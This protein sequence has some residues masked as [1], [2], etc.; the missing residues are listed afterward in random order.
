M[1]TL[2][3]K[4]LFF[5]L[6][7]GSLYLAWRSF[8]Q[9]ARVIQRGD[10]RLYMDELPRRIWR[11]LEVTVTQRTVFRARPW[12]SLMHGFVVWGFLFYFLANTGDVLEGYF[13][14][15]FL[16]TGIIG[17]VYRLAGDVLSVLIII[18]M[19]YFM[20]RRFVVRDPAL[21]YHE[22]VKLHPRIPGDIQR[23]SLIVGAF[24]LVHVGTRFLGETFWVALHGDDT[25]QPFASAV[26]GLWGGL[27]HDALEVG[28]HVLWWLA[29]GTIL[30]FIPYFPYSK[31]AHLF[32]GPLNY[33]SRPDRRSLGALDPLDFEDEAREQFGAAK[34]EHLSKTQIFDAFACIMCNRC[35]DACPAYV[36]G[37]ELSP[38]TLEINKR[39]EIKAHM[40]ALAAG[41]ESPSPLLDFAITPSA[42]WACTGCG[43]CIEIC[44][45]GNEPMFDIM[46]I[47]RDLVLTQGDFPSELQGAFRGMENAGN[48]WQVGESRMKWAEGLDVPTVEDTDN[49]EVLYWVGC[50]GSFEPRAQKIARALVRVLNAAGVKFA[51]L[52]DAESCTGDTARRAGNEY[53][54]YEMAK[55]NIETLNEVHPPR[56]L[57]TCPHCLHT[58]GKEYPQFGGNYDV[59]HHTTF[60]NELIQ[61]GRLKLVGEGRTNVTFHDPCYLGRHNGEYDAPRYALGA[62]GA[63]VTEMERTRNSSFCCGAGGAQFWK[64]EEHGT[65]R[66]NLTRYAEAKATGAETLATGC[67]F[68][69]RMFADARQDESMNG[70]P[71]VKDVVEIIA[72]RLGLEV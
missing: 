11:A 44:P 53:L 54:F 42:V 20:V 5:V 49:F 26:S 25:W 28:E 72:E 16:G 19:I 38:S 58:I 13:D 21:K 1:L 50:A 59:V 27:D 18:G 33:F 24:I 37:K 62:A 69:M 29:L 63:A 65:A 7:V 43:A 46:D 48:P 41:T 51:V 45:V 30:A 68:C 70:G 32:M 12:S 55:A 36:T 56:I 4:I 34:L 60:L 15:A 35:Q 10:G 40:G 61:A 2:I 47:R 64:E 9:A 31:H 39:L 52:G 6:A 23:D 57:V 71:E 3:E 66:V 8:R 14:I 67:P 17:D 22:N